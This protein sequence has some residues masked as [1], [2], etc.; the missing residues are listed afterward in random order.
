MIA[1]L[2]SYYLT[3]E[4]YDALMEFGIGYLEQEI[5]TKDITSQCKSALTR[6]YNKMEHKSPFALQS[7]AKARASGGAQRPDTEE[8]ADLDD[9][10]LIDSIDEEQEEEEE[11]LSKDKMVK[12]KKAPA[13]GKGKASTAAT[14]K[15]KA[16]TKAPRAIKAKSAKK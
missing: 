16:A 14:T 7:F 6:T 2:D 15:A 12:A 5:I 13:K 8:A 3:K 4:D 10:V 1:L 11:D 9:D